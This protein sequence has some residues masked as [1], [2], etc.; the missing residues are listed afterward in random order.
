MNVSARQASE[1]LGVSRQQISRLLAA[2]DIDGGRFGNVLEIDVDS[3]HRY[4]DLRPARGRPAREDTAWAALSNAQP[5]SLHALREMSIAM[6]RRAKRRR[7]RVLPGSIAR[8]LADPR[9]V[10]SGAG[11]AA[12][13]GAAVQDRPPHAIYVRRSEYHELAVEYRMR[14]AADA[15]LI[16]R[17]APDNAFVFTGGK[18]APLGVALLDLVDDRD[19]RSAAEALRDLA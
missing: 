9:V 16:V 19:D 7:V 4:Q 1:I 5:L 10:V 17:V 6:R 11:A 13:H 8:V 14:D 18:Y 15:N 3:L 12:H 2:G